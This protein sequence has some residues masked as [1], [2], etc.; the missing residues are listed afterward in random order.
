MKKLNFLILLV[1][2]VLFTQP[3]LAIED[4]DLRYPSIVERE[5][6]KLSDVIKPGIKFEH[7]Y[8]FG[9]TTHLELK[10]ISQYS[11]NV[12]GKSVRI[13]ARNEPPIYECQ[14]CGKMATQ[15]C[16]ECIYSDEGLLCD[17]CASKHEC[18]EDML[19]PVVNSPRVGVCGYTGD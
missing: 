8:D 2:L 10:V 3:L 15:I 11:G 18:D 4:E 14:T 16:C 6:F 9:S 1:P 12:K 17:D 7:E 13:L 5:P 19:L